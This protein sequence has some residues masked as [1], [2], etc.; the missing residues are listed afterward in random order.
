MAS[1]QKRANQTLPYRVM[2]RDGG[3]Q[4]SKSFAKL[5][6]AREHKARVELHQ[7]AVVSQTVDIDTAVTLYLEDRISC[8]SRE[9]VQRY[10]SVLNIFCDWLGPKRLDRVRQTDIEQWRNERREKCKPYTVRN[11][12]KNLRVFFGWCVKRGW[13][14]ESPATAVQTPKY[15]RKIPVWLDTLQTEALLG[16][17]R[18]ESAELYLVAL[19]AVRAGLRRKEIRELR[20]ADLDLGDA[21][22]VRVNETKSVEPRLVPL[23]PALKQALLDWPEVGPYVF[24]RIRGRQVIEEHHRGTAQGKVL[25]AWLARHGY[26]ITIH[27]LRHSFASHLAA[28]G[29]SETEIRDLLGHASLEITR[30]YTHSRDSQKR[31][32]VE[33][34]GGL[35]PSPA[36]GGG[37]AAPRGKARAPS[38]VSA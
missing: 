30:L 14:I 13:L 6:D 12:I 33:Q 28:A 26:G 16:E 4:H 15:K 17:L 18:A 38:A 3:R 32:H 9:T 19:F 8:C 22:L 31:V 20:W 23:H 10:M 27:G 11:D 24:P 21:P 5:G 7:V 2:W 1:I 29:A 35:P 37:K 25:N 34:L 36:T